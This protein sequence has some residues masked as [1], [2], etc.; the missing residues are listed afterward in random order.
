MKT[1]E[2]E[3]LLLTR[4]HI[5][6]VF[7]LYSYASN[8]NVGRPAGWPAHTSIW[9]SFLLIVRVLI[10]QGV[11]CIRPKGSKKAIGTIS[12]VPDKHRPGVRSMELG[13][14]IS[15]KYW[16]MGIMTEAVQ[17]MLRYGFEEKWFDMVCVTTGPDNERSQRVIEKAGFV[18]EGTLRK[19]FRLWDDTI[20]DLRCYSMTRDEYYE[21]K[22]SV[23]TEKR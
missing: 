22:K 13:Y 2:T 21:I 3:R 18:Y 4:W 7:D 17:E 6:D 1:L 10:P 19:A 14:S 12:F 15:E 23:Q 20:R 9:E 16:G 5:S 11:Y 8:P